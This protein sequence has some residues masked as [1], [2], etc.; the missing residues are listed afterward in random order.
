MKMKLQKRREDCNKWANFCKHYQDSG[1]S[2]E[3]YMVERYSVKAEA[4]ARSMEMLLWCGDQQL[5]YQ[6]QR[7]RD[8]R[9]RLDKKRSEPER[10][11]G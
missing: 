8:A 11:A 10:V 1:D 4:C 2:G 5:V 9:D 6:D 7:S 3:K